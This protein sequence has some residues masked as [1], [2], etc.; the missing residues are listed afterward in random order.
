MYYYMLLC[1]NELQDPTPKLSTQSAGEPLERG[2]ISMA[3]APSAALEDLGPLI[4]RQHALHLEEQVVLRR[5]ADRPVEEDDLGAGAL[6]LFHQDDLIGIASGQAVRGMDIEA[7]HLAGSNRIA[8]AL[9]RGAQ[10]GIAAVAVIDEAMLGPG[11]D[12][13]TALP[14]IRH[15][16]ASQH[17]VG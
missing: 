9:Q 12:T 15:A 10:Q 13:S 4:F 1:P 17:D 11:P 7:I 5:R 14:G 3:L 2:K 6:E 8:Q 16:S